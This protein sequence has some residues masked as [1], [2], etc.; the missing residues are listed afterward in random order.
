MRRMGVTTSSVPGGAEV[1]SV[2]ESVLLALP[3]QVL[4]MAL[5]GGCD[6]ASAHA[7]ELHR[8]D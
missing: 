3:D 6:I 4:N 1:A 5:E 7:F 8:S 2:A